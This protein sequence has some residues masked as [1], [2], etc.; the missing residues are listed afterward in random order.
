MRFIRRWRGTVS[1]KVNYYH[2]LR[3]GLF[4]PDEKR[5]FDILA[6]GGFVCK[7]S[8]TRRRITTAF[9]TIEPRREYPG[10]RL[11]R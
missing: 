7:Q 5:L 11:S 10:G 3:D 9:M 2:V 4:Q 8:Y 6:R 1:G